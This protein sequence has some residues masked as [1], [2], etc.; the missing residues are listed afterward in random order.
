MVFEKF[1][2][3]GATAAQIVDVAGSII[4]EWRATGQT[5]MRWRDF[6]PG[7]AEAFGVPA[8]STKKA[9]EIFDAPR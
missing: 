6:K 8:Y 7:L 3:I 1:L 2:K 5:G 9:R 4:D